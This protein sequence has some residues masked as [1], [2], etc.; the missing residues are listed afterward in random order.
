MGANNST[1]KA[2]GGQSITLNLKEKSMEKYLL[3][4]KKE[5]SLKHIE[6]LDLSRQELAEIP[7]QISKLV[8]LKILQ[9]YDNGLKVVPPEIGSSCYSLSSDVAFFRRYFSLFARR[10]ASAFLFLLFP[11][12][13][14]SSLRDDLS[15]SR[16]LYRG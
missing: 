6:R 11:F 10:E 4:L 12:F 15:P 13:L 1:G 16:S 2:K 14:N 7:P 9:M 3:E 8:G 5:S